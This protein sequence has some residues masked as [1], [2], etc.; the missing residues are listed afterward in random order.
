MDWIDVDGMDLGVVGLV[1]GGH[2]FSHFYLLAFPPLFPILRVE[3]GLSNVELGL[4]MSAVQLGTF[5]QVF[6]GDVVDRVG[7]KRVFVAGVLVTASGIGLASLADSYLLLVLFA[8]VSSLGQAAFHPADYALLDA[9]SD[10]GSEGKSFGLHNFA[11]SLGFAAGP[12]IVGGIALAA[13]WQAALLV[14]GGLGVGYAVL[15]HLAMDDV[16]LASLAEA[17]GVGGGEGGE[18]ADGV[19]G[20]DGVG[21][22]AGRASL[23]E[24]TLVALFVFFFVVSFGGFGFHSF[25]TVLVDVGFAL[26][27]A[28]GNAALSAFF[29]LSA[30]GV[31]TGGV[32]ADRVPPGRVI[33][34]ALLASALLTWAV[35]A[36]LVPAAPALVIAAF[37]AIG[38]VFGLLIPSRD[39]LVN[40]AVAKGSTGRS[41]GFVFTGISLA[42]VVSPAVLGAVIDATSIW[43]AFWIVG[44][45]FVGAAG[46]AG[47]IAAGRVPWAGS[48]AATN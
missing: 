28:T 38:G 27:E 43:T 21:R 31:L 29:T 26:P 3:F 18:R 4:I 37:A 39:R 22:T 36:G 14:A 35:A 9:A 13:G 1:S 24:P 40:A 41:F 48:P 42:G 5:L 45:A 46:V 17:E 16:H 8:F 20:D 30:I 44:A 12:A 15:A 32:I 25:T 19:G 23:R 33:L 11:G 7:G 6:A 10:A 47:V 34:P 2:F